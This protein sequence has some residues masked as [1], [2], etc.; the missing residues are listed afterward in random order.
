MN[1]VQYEA[2]HTRLHAEENALLLAAAGSRQRAVG[3][4]Q[5]DGLDWEYLLHAADQQ[6]VT[7]L[8]AAWTREETYPVPPAIHDRLHAAYWTNHF[9]NRVLLA[10]LR[11][12]LTVTAAAGISVMPLKGAALA[13]WYYAAAALRPM[14]DIDFLVR[15]ADAEGFAQ[16]LQ[17]HGFSVVPKPASVLN[18]QGEAAM[19]RE[20][21]FSAVVDGVSVLIEYRSEPLDPAIGP[22]LL[23]DNDMATRYH[24]HSARIWQRSHV[25][26]LDGVACARIAPED[27]VLHVAS[28]LTTRH[29]GLRLIWLHDLH[30][31]V[32]EHQ[33]DLDWDYV[34]DVAR[35]LHLAT[36]I[37]TALDASARWL[38]APIPR[39]Q[40]ARMWGVSERRTLWQA[41][42][43]RAFAAQVAALGQSNLAEVTSP[44]PWRSLALSMGWFFAGRAPWRVVGRI[45]VPSRA[46]MSW[47]YAGSVAS[48]RDYG[49]AV[50]F[51]IA[52]VCLTAV[53]AV[54]RRLRMRA[55]GR[56]TERFVQ[57]MQ[58]RT[59]YAAHHGA[60]GE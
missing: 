16:L 52:Y 4:V 56:F 19:F 39:G 13:T 8:L 38:G 18:E 31:I 27:L 30:Q 45:V 25:A 57:R 51:R 47:W 24:A 49:Y 32:S 23:A 36:P 60:A 15:P 40:L 5:P 50:A 35:H 33:D 10:Q 28:H 14:S 41:I 21:G 54:S 22:L 58:S 37:A 17:A 26:L 12:V 7:P 55:L 44:V 1:Q 6:G 53:S 59:A 48:R 34:C 9:R 29:A 46:Y 20:H 3:D 43:R 11:R 2:R 42:E